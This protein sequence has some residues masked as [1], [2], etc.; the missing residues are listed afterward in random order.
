MWIS[1]SSL[2]KTLNIYIYIL[3]INTIYIYINVCVY[4]LPFILCLWVFCPD[5]Y[6]C[7]LYVLVTCEGQKKSQDLLELKL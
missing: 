2:Q 4:T 5:V 7:T 6:L 1:K 3:N